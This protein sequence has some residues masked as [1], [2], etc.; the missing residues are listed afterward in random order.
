M[1][2]YDQA[3]RIYF[4][5]NALGFVYYYDV[6]KN[7]VEPFGQIP[8]GMSTAVTGNR[9]EIVQTSDGLKYLYIM[10]HSSTE[11]WRA[12]IFN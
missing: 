3:D 9:M 8:Y 11:M 4:T 5:P 2:V 10:R 7:I 6:V 12:L 1:F